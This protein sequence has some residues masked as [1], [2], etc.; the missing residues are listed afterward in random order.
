MTSAL[1]HL[2]LSLLAVASMALSAEAQTL[3]GIGAAGGSGGPVVV[4]LT[5][6]SGGPCG[7]PNGPFGQH[8]SFPVGPGACPG[9]T[10]FSGPPGIEG[11]VAVNRFADTIWAAGANQIGEYSVDGVQ[12]SG[13]MNPLGGAITG[14]GMNSTAGRLWVCSANQYAAVL[15]SCGAGTLSSGPFVSPYPAPMTDIAWD[16]HAGG[17]LWACFD[18]GTVG[19][20]TP[21][22]GA[23]LC[24]IDVT[25]LGLSASLTGLDM[26]TR[27]PGVGATN[28]SL[29][30][31]DSVLVAHVD[32][33]ISCS[34]GAAAL[35]PADFA[36]PNPVFSVASGALSGL[37]FAAHGVTYGA[38]SGPEIDLVGMAIP[39]TSPQLELLGAAPGMAALFVDVAAQCP[40]LKL[41]GENLFVLPTVLIGPMLHTGSLSIAAPLPTTVPIGLEI[42]MQWITIDGMTGLLEATPALTLT[43]VRP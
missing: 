25:S 29:F 1:S 10:P 4:E 23:L 35:A 24:S 22:A 6:G 16:P 33:I 27:S 2:T 30:V 39:G 18:D 38:G 11:D 32:A 12:L 40:P 37:A 7:Y 17:R 42:H 8:P 28:K 19:V 20:F 15:P 43:T 3:Y 26:D 14:L 13:F 31:T 21:G 5:G 9:P 41:K 36:F 34:S